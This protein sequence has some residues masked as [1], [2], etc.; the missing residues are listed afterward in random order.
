MDN[1]LLAAIHAAGHDVISY[2][3]NRYNYKSGKHLRMYPNELCLWQPDDI[4]LKS[5]QTEDN[6]KEAKTQTKC[7]LAGM[8]ALHV[9]GCDGDKVKKGA[10]NDIYESKNLI[11]TWN[12]DP[13]QNQYN[14]V[15]EILSKRQNIDALNLIA[16]CLLSCEEI[17]AIIVKW[18]IDTV[19]GKV[20]GVE[21]NQNLKKS[22]PDLY[23][24]LSL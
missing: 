13:L 4:F 11:T 21:F 1:K 8:A 22:F 15:I 24:M 14:Q 3:F 10:E 16:S 20:T 6:A 7:Y 23:E 19:D 9:V 17:P 5:L 12:L 18:M 2:R